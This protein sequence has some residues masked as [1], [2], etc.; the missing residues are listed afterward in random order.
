[1][2]FAGW[3]LI[4]AL[5]DAS[6]HSP[7]APGDDQEVEGIGG[8]A[9]RAA[10]ANKNGAYTRVLA[11][12]K[13]SSVKFFLVFPAAVPCDGSAVAAPTQNSRM[14]TASHCRTVA[15]TFMI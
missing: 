1:M 14:I 7:T 8:T 4:R 9:P 6:A 2:I 10:D 13:R 5:D 12:W 15:S 11:C 3:P